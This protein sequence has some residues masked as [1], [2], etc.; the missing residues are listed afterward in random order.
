MFV[1]PTA[2]NPDPFG[3]GTH[4][5]SIAAGS[6][7]YQQPESGGIAP[8]ATLFDIRVLDENGRGMLDDVLAGIDWV[9][10]RA[11]LDGNNIR[12]MNMSLGGDSTDSTLFDPL[13]I[14]ARSA[15]AAGIVVVTSAG[16][17]GKNAAGQTVLGTISSPG[18]E[19]SVI[20]VG[21]SNMKFTAA[22]GDD[23]MVTYSSRGPTRGT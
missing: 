20:T 15:T 23:L 18:H 6:G 13:A 14:A 3:H 5:A 22:R 1:A 9:I 4:V 11:Q 8:G 2:A 12:V 10:Q 21:A 7:A 19:A 17:A 16:N